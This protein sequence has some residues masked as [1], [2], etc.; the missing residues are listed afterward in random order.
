[1][2]RFL[3]AVIIVALVAVG[4]IYYINRN[5][6]TRPTGQAVA[7][8]LGQKYGRPT[9]AVQVEVQTDTGAFAKGS[10]RFKDQNGGGLWF[11]A[12]TDK[13]WELAYDGNGIIPC[14]SAN[15]YN[16]PKDMVPQCI[17]TQNNNNLVQR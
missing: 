2:K 8:L 15:R 4:V 14:S 7:E 9:D 12:K 11:A 13:G 3:L 6:D 5:N 10:V 17:D 1:M 16:L